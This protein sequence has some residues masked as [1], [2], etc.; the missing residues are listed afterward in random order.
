MGFEGVAL[1]RNSIAQPL[2]DGRVVMAVEMRTPDGW[3]PGLLV[4]DPETGADKRAIRAADAAGRALFPASGGGLLIAYGGRQPCNGMGGDAVASSVTTCISPMR[5][6]SPFH[7]MA[8]ISPFTTLEDVARYEAVF[9]EMLGESSPRQHEAAGPAG[10]RRQPD[11]GTAG[12]TGPPFQRR[13]RPAPK[14]A[15]RVQVDHGGDRIPSCEA[16][17]AILIAVVV[18]LPAPPFCDAMTTTSPSS[19]QCQ[20]LS[21]LSI[22]RSEREPMPATHRRRVNLTRP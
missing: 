10:R 15:L 8:L 13:S 12:A 16:A 21:D 19:P 7:N 4:L 3:R 2:G 1:S 14:A 22:S 18:C 20:P 17:T 5:R 11:R 9:A 6:W